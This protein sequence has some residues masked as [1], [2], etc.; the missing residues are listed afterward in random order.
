MFHHDYNA[1]IDYFA[2]WRQQY[3]AV[4]FILVPGNHDKLLNIDYEA[5]NIQLTTKEHWL[6]PFTIIHKPGKCRCFHN[7]RSY[8]SGVHNGRPGPAKLKASLFYR[9]T[10]ANNL[11]CF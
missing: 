5:L 4:E 6:E 10:A 3:S 1:D 11:T 7:Q 2:A 9:R 8:S